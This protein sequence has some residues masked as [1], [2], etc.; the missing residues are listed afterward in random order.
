MNEF[1]FN[2]EKILILDK[3]K[4]SYKQSLR[5]DSILGPRANFFLAFKNLMDAIR[6]SCNPLCERKSALESRLAKQPYDITSSRYLARKHTQY[7]VKTSPTPGWEWN[8]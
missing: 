7:V 8:V 4:F 6:F 5:A 2:H 3:T 1:H